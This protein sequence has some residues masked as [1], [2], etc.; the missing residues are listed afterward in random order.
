MIMT[1]EGPM[2]SGKTLSAVALAVN[3]KT[4][5]DKRIMS[6]IRL[7]GIDY[8]L[9]DQ[10]YLI[11]NIES[12][13]IFF[14]CSII[15]DN[16][17]LYA[18]SRRS[19]SNFNRI[20]SYLIL[21]SRRRNV[22]IYITVPD[23]KMLDVRIRNSVDSRGK[24]RYNSITHIVFIRVHDLLTN[25]RATFRF[26]LDDYFKYVDLTIPIVGNSNIIGEIVR[27]SNYDL[28]M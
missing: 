4:Q 2:G 24:C 23:L 19:Q 27:D 22:D 8:Q 12:S 26:D 9:F 16:A 17:Y 10:D 28:I 20:F 25:V 21:Q 13:T 18:D 11:R 15:L 14:D 6:N 3:E 7:N 5:R 1:L